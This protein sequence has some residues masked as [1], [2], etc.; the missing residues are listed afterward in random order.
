MKIGTARQKKA[1]QL[2]QEHVKQGRVPQPYHQPNP[3]GVQRILDVKTLLHFR[4]EEHWDWRWDG[5]AEDLW[6]ERARMGRAVWF[7]Y[8]EGAKNSKQPRTKEKVRFYVE[9]MKEKRSPIP[10]PDLSVGCS[11]V[12]K[13][14]DE[15]PRSYHF[16][17]RWSRLAWDLSSRKRRKIGFGGSKSVKTCR[18]SCR[19]QEKN[20]SDGWTWPGKS[21]RQA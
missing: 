2:Y 6:R 3:E 19:K 20:H 4:G 21:S 12:N 16:L 11:L 7:T 8:I 1:L 18:E 15:E 9:M 5:E 17:G 13:N 14:E 10:I